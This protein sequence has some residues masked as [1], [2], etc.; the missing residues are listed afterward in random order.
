[1]KTIHKS[2]SFTIVWNVYHNTTRLPFDFTGKDVEVS[3]FSNSY[4]SILKN[5]SVI[6]NVITADISAD[7]LPCGV[8]SIVC[9]YSTLDEKAYTSIPNAFQISI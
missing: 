7:E 3:L 4:K 2:H 9:R 8:Y 1:M 6:D 5:Y